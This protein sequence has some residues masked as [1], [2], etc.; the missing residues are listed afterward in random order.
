MALYLIAR[1]D[2]EIVALPATEI[3]SVV[4]V[5]QIAAGRNCRMSR[6][7]AGTAPSH[8]ETHRSGRARN[9]GKRSPIER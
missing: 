7:P 9:A 1:I 5:D 8:H 2:Q 3:G 6:R 4:E